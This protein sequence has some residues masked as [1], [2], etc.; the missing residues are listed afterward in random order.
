MARQALSQSGARQSQGCLSAI[1]SVGRTS[2]RRQNETA[3]LDTPKAS[4]LNPDRPGV[5]RKQTPRVRRSD[6]R[7]FQLTAQAQ[8][9]RHLDGKWDRIGHITARAPNEHR[10]TRDRGAPHCRHSGSRSDD[11]GSQTSRRAAKVSAGLLHRH[12][13]AAR[14]ADCPMLPPAPHRNRRATTAVPSDAPAI[15]TTKVVQKRHRQHKAD[16]RQIAGHGRCNSSVFTP[17]KQHN[18][19]PRIAK[20]PI[21][22]PTTWQNRLALSTLSTM[23]ASGLPSRCL[24]SRRFLPHRPVAHH[25]KG[26]TRRPFSATICPARSAATTDESVSL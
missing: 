5:C 21:P 20:R 7:R 2:S 6:K 3:S 10:L 1:H 23:T 8:S 13:S 26:D 16:R 15:Q 9:G 17:R 11:R 24:R 12:K 18:R 14:R 25:T 4:P 19:T 22:R